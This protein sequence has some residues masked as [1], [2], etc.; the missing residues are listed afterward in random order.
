[1]SSEGSELA[2]WRTQKAPKIARSYWKLGADGTVLD[3]MYAV[4]ADE[5]EHRDV[6]H[7]CS[8][9]KEGEPNPVSNTQE[10][11]NTML[12]K[13]VRDM[14]ERDPDKPLKMAQP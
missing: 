8:E 9:M 3:L 11:L 13:Y 5:A 12:L 1:M 6:N 4:R 14:M 2:E 7:L 10:K